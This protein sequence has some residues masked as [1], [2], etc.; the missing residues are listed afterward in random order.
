MSEETKVQLIMDKQTFSNLDFK[1]EALEKEKARTLKCLSNTVSNI[2]PVISISMDYDTILDLIAKNDSPSFH[3]IPT[4]SLIDVKKNTR[5][6]THITIPFIITHLHDSLPCTLKNLGIE[7]NVTE[8]A[9]KKWK[10]KQPP[11]WPEA[12]LREDTIS[13][14]NESPLQ[15]LLKE[16]FFSESGGIRRSTYEEFFKNLKQ[17]LHKKTYN[18]IFKRF[19]NP[20]NHSIDA[21]IT[22]IIDDM[23]AYYKFKKKKH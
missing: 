17:T 23:S 4:D 14:N 1:T 21:F 22:A 16:S 6:E 5:I 15:R 20:D 2:Q 13:S 10:A 12:F 11:C 7:F 18:N 9:V 8:G 3:M 19:E